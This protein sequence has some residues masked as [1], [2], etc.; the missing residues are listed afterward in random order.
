MAVEDGATLGHLLGRFLQNDHEKAR[1]PR[2]LQIY[3]FIR[4]N[5]T[6]TVVKTATG[7]RELFHMV[8]GPQQ[9]E[10]DRL[11][12]EHDWFD[13]NRSFP[14]VF[15]D[16]QYLREL[17]GFDTLANADTAFAQFDAR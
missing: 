9:Q 4:K 2:L 16:L 1:I 7:N 13:E 17:Y 14:W 8:D 12:S 15:A 10:R 5:R 3:E 11:L 6:T